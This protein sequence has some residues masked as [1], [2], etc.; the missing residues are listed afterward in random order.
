MTLLIFGATGQVARELQRRAPGAV[1]LD[2]SAADLSDPAACAAAIR[3]QAPTAVINAAAWTAVDKAETEEAAATVINGAAPTAMAEACA[4]LG[5]P[6][7]QISTD[8][9]FDGTGETAFLPDHPTAPLGAYGRGKLTGEDGVRAAGGAYA[10]LRASWV[11]SAHGA[12]LARLARSCI[13]G[14]LREHVEN[15]RLIDGQT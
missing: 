3:A 7:V 13:F 1:Y 5:V 4:A 15:K 2:R 12:N 8:Y 10:I 6:F 14:L 11:F 9:V